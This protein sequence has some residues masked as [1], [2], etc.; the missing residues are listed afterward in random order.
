MTGIFGQL[1][2]VYSLYWIYVTQAIN[3]KLNILIKQSCL[4]YKQLTKTWNVL[5]LQSMLAVAGSNQIK[6]ARSSSSAHDLK[7]NSVACC[8]TSAL[9]FNKRGCV[10]QI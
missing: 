4:Q 8:I 3:D 6:P 10:R 1:L 2:P 9:D 5:H 7:G